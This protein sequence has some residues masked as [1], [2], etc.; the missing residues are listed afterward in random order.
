MSERWGQHPPQAPATCVRLLEALE[1]KRAARQGLQDGTSG[2]NS[3]NPGS[4][5]KTLPTPS[6]SKTE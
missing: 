4:Q 6:S 2:L 1:D 5:L 3:C